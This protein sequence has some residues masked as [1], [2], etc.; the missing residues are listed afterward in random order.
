MADTNLLNVTLYTRK[1]CELCE[2]AKKDLESLAKK[3]PHRL[4]EVDID[5]D[6]ALKQKYGEQIPVIEVGPY[7]LKAPITRQSLEMTLG[8]ANDRRDQLEQVGGNKY[9]ERVQGTDRLAQ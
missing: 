2:Q 6:P 7:H 5:S 4:A 9:Q 8:A 3:F 1:D